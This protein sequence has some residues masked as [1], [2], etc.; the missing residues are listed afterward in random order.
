MMRTVYEESQG[1]EELSMLQVFSTTEVEC[2][3]LESWVR[4]GWKGRCH[5]VQR[6]F[7]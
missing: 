3:L 4:T 5:S 6:G 1:M 2:K 7:G